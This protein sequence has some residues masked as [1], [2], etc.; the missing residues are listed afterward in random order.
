MQES[1]KAREEGKSYATQTARQ[2][3]AAVERRQQH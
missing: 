1:A 2:A 3:A